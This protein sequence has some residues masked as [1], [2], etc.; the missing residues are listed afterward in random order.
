M[1]DCC[2][3]ECGVESF[4]VSVSPVSTDPRAQVRGDINGEFDSVR[5]VECVIH[6]DW[7]SHRPTKAL[8]AVGASEFTTANGTVR[9]FVESTRD[10]AKY[11]YA[12]VRVE[13]YVE[14]PVLTVKNHFSDGT[15]QRVATYTPTFGTNTGNF[16]FTPRNSQD[17]DAYTTAAWPL[18]DYTAAVV[19]DGVEFGTGYIAD[20]RFIGSRLTVACGHRYG[21][22]DTQIAGFMLPSSVHG[23]RHQYGTSSTGFLPTLSKSFPRTTICIGC[24]WNDIANA[25]ADENATVRCGLEVVAEP[26]PIPGQDRIATASTFGYFSFPFEVPRWLFVDE[27]SEATP[28]PFDLHRFCGAAADA[29]TVTVPKRFSPPIGGSSYWESGDSTAPSVGGMS[30]H[31]TCAADHANVIVDPDES[32]DVATVPYTAVRNGGGPVTESDPFFVRRPDIIARVPNTVANA[33]AWHATH[34]VRRDSLLATRQALHNLQLEFVEA[35]SPIGPVV[36]QGVFANTPNEF[37]MRTWWVGQRDKG[38]PGSLAALAGEG[39]R[40]YFDVLSDEDAF[41]LW[42]DTEDEFRPPDMWFWNSTAG[43]HTLTPFVGDRALFP[44]A[45]HKHYGSAHRTFS[46][47]IEQPSYLDIEF[48][49]GVGF[50]NGGRVGLFTDSAWEEHQAVACPIR[51][52]DYRI[53]WS[54]QAYPQLWATTSYNES[55]NANG[56]LDVPLDDSGMTTENY[57]AYARRNA[58]ADGGI[59]P[60]PA[61]SPNVGA[62]INVRVRLG[63]KWSITEVKGY[64]RVR[65]KVEPGVNIGGGGGLAGGGGT[66]VMAHYYDATGEVEEKGVHACN[67]VACTEVV[68][69]FKIPLTGDNLLSLSNGGQVAK[70]LL[71]GRMNNSRFGD[72]VYRTVRVRV[73]SP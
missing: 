21:G 5:P 9:A 67:D 58:S 18:S 34:L 4:S 46:N 60:W 26:G 13:G 36:R 29:T 49:R 16:V 8:M 69:D 71:V 1:S 47:S 42:I 68:Q 7:C 73:L 41:N 56:P 32:E 22:V 28:P 50:V 20:N 38:F 3:C 19:D 43:L 33:D 40:F 63:L 23:F 14:F 52:S 55:G 54:V 27:S 2:G 51:K 15:T 66:V 70:D 57:D 10:F 24:D 11:V 48:A 65:E 72:P 45:Y 25:N 53:A 6:A 31:V 12:E 30:L 17:N 64:R 35:S 37:P 62:T 44:N 59:Y 39:P 61:W